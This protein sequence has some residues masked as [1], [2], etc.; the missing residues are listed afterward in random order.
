MIRVAPLARSVSWFFGLVLIVWG[1]QLSA[2]AET[3]EFQRLTWTEIAARLHTGTRTLLIPLGGTEQ[4]G[5]FLAVG[6]HNIRAALQ[7]RR[8]AEEAGHTMVAPVVSYVPEGSVKPRS[9]H[10]RFAGTISVT[11]K[12]FEALLNDAA[13]SF[14]VQ[15]FTCVVFLADHGGY[16]SYVTKTVRALNARWREGG[17]AVYLGDYYASLQQRFSPYLRARG[18]GYALGKHADLSDT[19]LLLALDPS[20]VRL[21]ALRH[22]ALPTAAQGVYGGDPRPASAE[23]G[24]VGAEIQVQAAVAE[25]RR[26]CHLTSIQEH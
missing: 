19:A 7:A 17:K 12:V 16:Q 20:A 18:Y 11:P 10:M 21:E 3:V 6:K 9:S 14:R 23:F 2:Q 13:E 24:R 8:I 22:A 26:Q 25:L 15:G 4:S 1:C 5:P